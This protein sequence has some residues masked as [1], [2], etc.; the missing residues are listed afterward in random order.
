MAL[1]VE[2]KFD[3]LSILFLLIPGI[4]TW[5]IVKSLGPKRPRSDFESGLQIFIYG[6][7]GYSLAGFGEVLY[8]WEES[9]PVGKKFWDVAGERI[10]QILTLNP[11]ADLNFK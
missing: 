5:G 9:P 6:V 7:V 1:P 4:I 10:F 8:L 2:P 11:N 3:G